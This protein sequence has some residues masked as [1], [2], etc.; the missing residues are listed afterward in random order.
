MLYT[1]S[2]NLITI[3]NNH[4]LITTIIIMKIE[5]DVSTSSS[6]AHP[7]PLKLFNQILSCKLFLPN[8]YLTT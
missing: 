2:L 3:I 1:I 5:N 6:S 8:H 7:L 4:L